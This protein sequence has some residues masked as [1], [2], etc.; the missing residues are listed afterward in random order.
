MVFQIGDEIGR[1]K[2]L[3]SH[4]GVVVS[5]EPGPTLVAHSHPDFEDGARVTS[6]SE[7]SPAGVELIRVLSRPDDPEQKAL[8]AREALSNVGAAWELVWDNC[9]SFVRRA[10]GRFPH[11]STLA[12]IGGIA[13]L[14]YLATKSSQAKRHRAS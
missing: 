1:P 5:V 11:G 10:Q 8:V 7:F 12:V 14:F 3:V 6:L 9:H 4:K 13:I 2:G